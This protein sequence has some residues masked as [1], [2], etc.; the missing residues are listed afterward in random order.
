MQALLN[1]PNY[2]NLS[3]ADK[4]ELIKEIHLLSKKFAGN[5]VVGTSMD[6]KQSTLYNILKSDGTKGL[7]DAI[8]SDKI[9]TNQ[10]IEKG[11]L[12]SD[13]TVNKDAYNRLSELFNND[14]KALELYGNAMSGFLKDTGESLGGNTSYSKL[15]SYLDKT[16]MTDVEKG[17][18]LYGA[19]SSK[20]S[21]EAQKVF[22]GDN[23]EDLYNFYAKETGKSSSK[24]KES[25]IPS[26]SS[27]NQTKSTDMIEQG[28][29]EYQQKQEEEAKRQEAIENNDISDYVSSTSNGGKR[30]EKEGL[31][32][33]DAMYKTDAEKSKAILDSGVSTKGV[34]KTR[35][36]F[37]DEAVYT[38]Y[39]YK[40]NADTDGN[41][42]VKKDEL[43]TYLKSIGMSD[44]EIAQWWNVFKK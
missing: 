39:S 41:G 10:A 18:V 9:T 33:L 42:Y 17:M 14:E 26:P 22:D 44:S 31:P 6:S 28:A 30:F 24:S 25:K 23:Y 2:Q 3:D 4:G 27:L 7:S 20:L 12:K 38:Y 36:T 15:I 32:M 35:A 5:D 16:N 29:K 8:L 1:N 34:E 19:K 40:Q 37:G 43:T 13:G 11:F 21:K